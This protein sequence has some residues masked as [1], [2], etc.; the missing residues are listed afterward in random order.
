MNLPDPVALAIPGFVLAI[1]GEAWWGRRAGAVRYEARDA[2]ASLVMGFG[3]TVTALGT[4]ALVYAA[5]AAVHAH[6]LFDLPWAWWTFVLCFFAEDLAYY[7]FHRVSHERRWFWA[8]H[9]VHHSSQHYNLSTALRQ[10][11]TGA[12][13][14]SFVF[15]LPLPFLGFPPEMVLFFQGTSLV[16][17]F[18]IHTEA[19]RSLGP[20]EAVLNT[21]AHHRVHH[22]TAPRCLDRNYAGVLIV[23]DRL[24]G[25]FEPERGERLDYGIVHPIATFN[26]L[27]IALHEW[28]AMARDLARART[29]R[30]VLGHL[31]GPP[32][33]RP[34]GAGETTAA[35][36]ASTG[37]RR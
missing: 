34:D 22:A 37:P 3:F 7:A 26:P 30:A 36:R 12:I 29:P 32:G 35:L 18:W 13:S 14:G 19:I 4:G 8:S 6:R 27:R 21:P 10:S 31:L 16:Y 28:A 20:L 17:Q 9:V 2:L 24:F 5:Y 25:T 33:W 1:L 23:W 11:W 15:W